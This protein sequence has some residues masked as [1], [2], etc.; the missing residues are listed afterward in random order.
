MLT[1][2]EFNKK[3]KSYLVDGSYGLDFNDQCII[4][5]L[6][7]EFEYEYEIKIN[8]N[9]KYKQIKIKFWS[10][11]IYATSSKVKQWKLKIDEIINS[12]T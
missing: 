11:K 12:K 5:Y 3:W 6:D 1:L 9:F 7:C 4:S 2:F 10:C 8:P